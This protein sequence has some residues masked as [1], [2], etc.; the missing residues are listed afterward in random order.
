MVGGDGGKVGEIR[1]V[2]LSYTAGA[3][4]NGAGQGGLP[5]ARERIKKMGAIAAA[6]KNPCYRPHFFH[7]A[8]AGT[9]SGGGIKVDD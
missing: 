6:E 5:K 2:H 7:K 8:A 1:N 9:S 4:R 3:D